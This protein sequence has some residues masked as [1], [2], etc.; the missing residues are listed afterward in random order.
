MIF[1][2]AALPG[3]WLIEIELMSDERGHFARS[4]C[5]D[6]FRDHGIETEFVQSSV[7]FNTRIGTLRGLHFQS[8]PAAEGK[9]VRCTR[10]AIFDVVLDLRPHSPTYLRW[11]SFELT[12]VNTAAVFVPPGL[13]HGF[14]TLADE[15]EVFY[16]MTT[17][18][19]PALA[20]GV[21]WNDSAF[22]ITWPIAHPTLSA[23]DAHYPDFQS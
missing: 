8:A 3:V 23:R 18:Y 5:H 15:T 19:T 4:F 10:G 13:A 22:G 1:T 2:E 17:R 12:A 16:Q 6:A 7:S 9:L 11:Q 21:R 20:S 14:Q